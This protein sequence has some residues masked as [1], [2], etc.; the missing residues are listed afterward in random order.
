MKTQT[1]AIKDPNHASAVPCNIKVTIPRINAVTQTTHPFE[2]NRQLTANDCFLEQ[3][4][5][6]TKNGKGTINR[7]LLLYRIASMI[8]NHS[9]RKKLSS[10]AKLESFQG[11]KN[12]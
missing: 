8:S 12:I 5:A 7:S 6:S 4:P 1:Q 10:S 3:K 11:K 9:R 2:D